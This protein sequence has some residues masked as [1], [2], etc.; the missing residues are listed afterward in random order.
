[1]AA[2]FDI[3]QKGPGRPRENPASFG[4]GGKSTRC[5]ILLG[6]QL[7][8]YGFV[9]F[10]PLAVYHWRPCFLSLVGIGLLEIRRGSF[11]YYIVQFSVVPRDLQVAHLGI[12]C[13]GL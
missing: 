13:V 7:I 10:L 1:M 8:R 5:Q 2:L 9:L 11:F 12:I 6:L 3:M 4:R